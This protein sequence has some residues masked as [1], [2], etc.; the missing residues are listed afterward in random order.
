MNT[1]LQNLLNQLNEN[2]KIPEQ[3]YS[4]QEEL[5]ELLDEE[6]TTSNLDGGEG[7]PNTPYAFR[8][9][10][11]NPKDLSYTQ[12]VNPTERF[13]RKWEVVFNDL[14]NSLNE[15]SYKD[16]KSDSTRNE[17]QKINGHIIEINKK[18]REVEQMINHA[19]K[20]K[21]ETGSDQ[22]VF[23][24]GTLGNFLKIKERLNRLS[25]KITEFNS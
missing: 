2:F 3:Q 5:D 20:L 15:V 12:S 25:N 21:L 1:S 9:K 22:T 8:K 14:Q 16:Y 11:K 19:S 13:Y 23:W 7:Q 17:R 24:K 18:L 10:V 4:S 6:N